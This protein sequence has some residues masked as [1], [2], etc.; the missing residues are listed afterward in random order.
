VGI[1]ARFFLRGFSVIPECIQID[2][3]ERLSELLEPVV[4]DHGA[5]LVDLELTGA[6]NNQTLRLLI[7]A[8]SGVTLELCQAISREAADLLDIEDPIKNRYRLEITSPGLDR[9]LQSDRDFARARNRF[10][11]IVLANG[12]TIHGR[13]QAW[14]EERLILQIAGGTEELER[15]EIAKATIEVEF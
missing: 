6:L 7:H 3:K 12:K 8:D 13:L 10:L 14:E 9:P 4:M 15:R 2:L 5:S 11:K 1:K